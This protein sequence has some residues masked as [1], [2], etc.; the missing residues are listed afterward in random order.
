L[1]PVLEKAEPKLRAVDSAA[2]DVVAAAVRE[3]QTGALSN[4]TI[5]KLWL[6]F[7]PTCDWDDLVGDVSLGHE[8]FEILSELRDPPGVG[9]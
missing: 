3:M 8:V 1:Q 7:A 2:A 5:E 9:R 6:I 4:Q